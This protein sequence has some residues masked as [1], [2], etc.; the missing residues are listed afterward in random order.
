MTGFVILISLMLLVKPSIFEQLSHLCNK[1]ILTDAGFFSM[2]KLTGV[3]L[4]LIGLFLVY[5]AQT[6]AHLLDHIQTM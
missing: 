1:V 3:L 4:I 6:Q 5:L 2:P